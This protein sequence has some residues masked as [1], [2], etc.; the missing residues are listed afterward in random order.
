MKKVS[1]KELYKI[2]VPRFLRR[3]RLT[4]REL[5]KEL[6]CSI[7]LVGGWA[8][9]SGVP[10]Y[11]KCA[12]LLKAGMTVSELFGE[13][14]AKETLLFPL[15]EDPAKKTYFEQKVEEAV[16]NYID[17]G[18]FAKKIYSASEILL[19]S[20]QEHKEFVHSIEQTLSIPGYLELMEKIKKHPNASEIFEKFE[21]MINIFFK[22]GYN[23]STGN[24]E[25]EKIER[26]PEYV[27]I[28]HWLEKN[29]GLRELKS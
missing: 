25:L 8:N 20:K 2:D 1:K 23:K 3:K 4:Q 13:E 17:S 22:K 14:I 16:Q 10:S 21:E 6:N 26:L 7:G 28:I 11:E 5:A 12:E 27:E 9:R 15:G 29:T 24:Y 18:G 19:S